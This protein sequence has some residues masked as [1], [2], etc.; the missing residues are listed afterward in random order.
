MLRKGG[1]RGILYDGCARARRGAA[2]RGVARR[3]GHVTHAKPRREITKMLRLTTKMIEMHPKIRVVNS[4]L[5]TL[6]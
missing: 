2:W 1:G 4:R 5:I 3:G 6:N